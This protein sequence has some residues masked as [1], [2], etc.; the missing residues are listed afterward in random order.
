[1]VRLPL[2]ACVHAF[3]P[4][5]ALGALG[6]PACADEKHEV[7]EREDPRNEDESND[8][9]ATAKPK[10]VVAS[11]VSS[12]DD[13]SSMYVSFLDSLDGQEVDHRNGREFPGSSDLWVHDG[14]IFVSDY[15]TQ[16]ITKFSLSG[17][18]LV[19]EGR[20]GL[21][22]YDVTSFGFWMNTFVAEDKAYIVATPGTVIIWNTEK[23]E[24]VDTLELP[25]PEGDDTHR[26]VAAYGDRASAIR[27]GLFY[28][29]VYYADDSYFDFLPHSTLHVIDV[30]SD[31]VVETI[32][33]PC[34]GLDFATRFDDDLYFSSWVF[35]PGG[36][37][38][39]DGPKT[40]VVKVTADAPTEA[41]V[42]FDIADITDGLEGGLFRNVGTNRAMLSV[43][44]RSH[45]DDAADVAT[46]AFG[47]N[48]RFWSYETETGESAP[49]EGIDWN[50]GSA[51]PAETE[52]PII[53]V[54]SGD[55][56]D[57]TAYDLSGDK[58]KARLK[59][60]GWTLR[61]FEL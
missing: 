37:A 20:M 35:A 15:E 9:G 47:A 21:G 51:Y 17:D 60:Q 54:P 13:D 55:Y 56:S 11:L 53:L 36:A 30:E 39:L 27:D 34:P 18:E 10:Y 23:M 57:T 33:T 49:I 32:E 58:A 42:A 40:C 1:M 12:S 25:T 50:A 28:L 29:P 6:F 43:L 3:T 46:I 48:W 31:E 16:I 5:L 7:L 61:L 4:L 52:A 2:R 8:A 26:A 44:D 22:A 14:K 59:T 45:A 19:E 38:V 24:I 41:E